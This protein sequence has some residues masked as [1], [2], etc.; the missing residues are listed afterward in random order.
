MGMREL[1]RRVQSWFRSE[2]EIVSDVDEEI[3]FH[4]DMRVLRL[5]REGLTRQDAE[6]RARREFGDAGAL[7]RDLVERD[8]RS[9]RRL[10]FATWLDDVRQDLRFAWRGFVR[11]PGFTMV[12]V[13]T[14]VLGIGACVAMFTVVNGVLLRPLPYPQSTRLAQL[15]PGQNFCITL[16]DA[17]GA[18]P[19]VQASTGIAQWGLT[20]TGEG[21]AVELQAQ[22]VDAAFFEVFGVT[23]AY[24]RPFRADERDP[25]NSDVVILSHALWQ[26][27][28]GGDPAIIGRRVQLDGYDKTSREVIGVMPRGFVAPMVH[29]SQEIA[30]WI[31]LHLP[32]GRALRNDSTWYVNNVVALLR[33]GASVET[34]AREVNA[35][36]ER[37]REESGLI[38]SDES[39]RRLGAAS[40]V[41]S[42]VG[43]TRRPL[44]M[45]LGAVGLVLLLAC[46]N[47]AN[48][49]L[50]RGERRRSELAARAAL[51][52]TR[53]RLVREL[54]TESALLAVIGA[55]GGV[56]F[57]QL[58][59]QLLR[60][61]E[62][63]GLPRSTESFVIDVRVLAF[64]AVATALAVFLFALLPA[65]RV[66]AGDL[67]PALGSGRRSAGVTV[68]GRR[69]G[70]ALIAVEIALAMML[71][72]GAALLIASFRSVR[73]VDTG[74]D[75]HD[76]LAVRVSPVG[77]TYS[78]P[79]A[80][81]LYSA[82]LERIRALPGV[83]S[84]GGI[85]LMP[86]TASNWDFPYLAEGHA[87]PVNQ[88]LESANFRVVSGDYFDAVDVEVIR[89][90]SFEAQDAQGAAAV[91]MINRA[92]AEKLWPD[93]DPIGREI[94]LFGDQPFRVVG[95]VDDVR[96]H[97][98]RTRPLP[99]MYLPLEQYTLSSMV[100]MVETT[101]DPMTVAA[102]VRDAIRE[103]D[104]DIAVP[105]IRVLSEVMGESV[106][107]DRFFAQ[108]LTFFGIIAL[109]LGGVGVYGVMMYAVSARVPEFSIRLALGATHARVV[110]ESLRSGLAPVAIGLVAGIAASL[111]TGSA[112]QSLLYGVSSSDPLI[113]TIAAVVLG[114]TAFLAAWL[115][116]RRVHRVEPMTVLNSG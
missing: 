39:V 26:S 100:L 80:R 16:A 63:A 71:V 65:L 69:L 104:A 83:R 114:G 92:L 59:L 87:P 70:S 94:K 22:V 88:P 62:T 30:M 99:E 115:P 14:L 12:A 47:L 89:G 61:A 51:G 10:R 44:L 41:E 13:S 34:A 96:Q 31:P 32:P 43:D 55:L 108:V 86:F 42:L 74:I 54:V 33:P 98:L 112:L 5:Q 11:R 72:T 53:A 101:G 40:L 67:R 109:L 77:T 60:V 116:M 57:A 37:A 82:L 78:G 29:G 113:I 85:H 105:E 45:L 3:T 27:T 38:I 23:P 36:L 91:G 107:R 68:G 52:G 17:A 106:A 35:A 49:M 8:M 9:E 28:F 25:A 6:D 7:R 76:V 2:H 20:L 81:Q 66:T 111:L 58:T 1:P 110:R 73:A 21:D 84:A 90:R 50:A 24:G 97:S 95:V 56:L 103:H 75:S 18:I 4:L 102:A 19:S 46:A 79:A 48:L 93:Q 64:T 15:W